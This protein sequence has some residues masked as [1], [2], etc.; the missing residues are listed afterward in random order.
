MSV[1]ANG[2][3]VAVWEQQSA[4]FDNINASVFDA[5]T[6]SWGSAVTLNSESLADA[7][8]PDIQTDNQ[9]NA[10]AVWLQSDGLYS[11]I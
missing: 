8:H 6:K 7:Q 11:N 2:D 5:A 9:G 1:S 10:V 4:T 3:A